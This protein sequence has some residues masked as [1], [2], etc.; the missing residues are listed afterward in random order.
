MLANS[1]ASTWEHQM[2][3]LGTEPAILGGEYEAVDLDWGT[4]EYHMRNY[5]QTWTGSKWF[6]CIPQMT[7]KRSKFAAVNVPLP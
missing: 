3:F 1:S 2:A 5:V 7:Y 6:C 4:P